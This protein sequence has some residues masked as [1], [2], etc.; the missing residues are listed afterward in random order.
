MTDKGHRDMTGP[1]PYRNA[2]SALFVASILNLIAPVVGGGMG[3]VITGVV[4][5]LLGVGLLRGMRW[6]AYLAFLIAG[7][8][9]AVALGFYWAIGWFSIAMMLA[10]WAAA[11]MLFPVLWRPA[12][13]PQST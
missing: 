4:L 3:F 8:A 6:V 5:C 12:S 9:G 10:S 13:A 1:N 7:I 2:A 11:V